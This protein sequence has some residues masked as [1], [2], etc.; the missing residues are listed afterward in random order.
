MG[1]S[2]ESDR[3]AYQ[4]PSRAKRFRLCSGTGY[5]GT[6]IEFVQ[7]GVTA[8]TPAAHVKKVFLTCAQTRTASLGSRLNFSRD[9]ARIMFAPLAQTCNTCISQRVLSDVHAAGQNR[10]TSYL[11]HGATQRGFL[12][13][14]AGV[15]SVTPAFYAPKVPCRVPITAL[16]CRI[17]SIWHMKKS[18]H[19]EKQR[20]K[21]KNSRLRT[22]NKA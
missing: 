14:W 8:V 4:V 20:Y 15:T 1:R 22:K 21:K 3:Y 18:N 11:H 10:F 19:I 12:T 13:L 5:S 6:H 16:V 17:W 9:A 7:A 2:R